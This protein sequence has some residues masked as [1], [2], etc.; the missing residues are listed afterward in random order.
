MATA[1]V[2]ETDVFVEFETKLVETAILV[3]L[4]VNFSYKKVQ[5]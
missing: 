3:V 1:T 2:K 4:W 5:T